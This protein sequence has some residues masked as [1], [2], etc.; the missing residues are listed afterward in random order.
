MADKQSKWVKMPEMPIEVRA[1]SIASN[2]QFI[3][4]VGGMDRGGT[5]NDLHIYDTTEKKWFK[6]TKFP[7]RGSLRGFGSSATFFSGKLYASDSSNNIYEFNNKSKIWL[8]RK[9]KLNQPRF[10][11]RMVNYDN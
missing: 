6:S 1:F 5:L 3:F 8:N 7:S 10:F 4:I 2:D 9:E 11:H